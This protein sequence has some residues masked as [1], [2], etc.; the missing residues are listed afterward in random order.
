MKRAIISP[1]DLPM[2]IK[3]SSGL[4][5]ESYQDGYYND[6]DNGCVG[7]DVE[8]CVHVHSPFF[9]RGISLNHASIILI[10]D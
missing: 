2:P 10:R 1:I 8:Y 4:K 9:V 3:T 5:S 7:D 6:G